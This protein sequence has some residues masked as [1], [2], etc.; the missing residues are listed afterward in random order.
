MGLF[1]I[2]SS[3]PVPAQ[4]T[5]AP[6]PA[7]AQGGIPATPLVAGQQG[8]DGIPS[9]TVP[10]LD[11]NSP[12]PAAPVDTTPTSPL[13]TFKTLW[14]N[15]P[16]AEGAEPSAPQQLT[17][18]MIQ[19]AMGSTSFATA[20]TP[21]NMEAISLGGEAA[22][23]AFAASM[24]AVARQVMTQSV[25]VGNKLAETK[26]DA[27]RESFAKELP[28]LLRHQSSSDHLKTTNPLFTNPAVKP[29]VEAAQAQL[30]QKFPDASPAEITEMTEKYI[31]TMGEAFAPPAPLTVEQQNQTDWEKFL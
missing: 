27:A 6:A 10:A 24:E 30:L 7:P 25:L 17:P 9:G 11:S 1:D 20:I 28:S 31:L 15:V 14:E 19:K 23:Q 5:P 12:T 8:A 22:Q 3:A 16:I 21:E 29:V 26:V 18:E 2:F 4:Q 13:D